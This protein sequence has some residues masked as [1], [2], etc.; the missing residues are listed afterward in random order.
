MNKTRLSTKRQ[1][2][3]GN[4]IEILEIRKPINEKFSR[5][6]NGKFEKAKT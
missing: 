5:G 3:K 6:F 4:Q 1:I 2:I